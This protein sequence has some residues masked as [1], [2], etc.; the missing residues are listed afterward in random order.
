M[1]TNEWQEFFKTEAAVYN[2]ESFT[3]S[4]EAE[5]AFLLEEFQL[6]PGAAILDIGC[7]TGRHSLALAR[8]GFRMTGVDLSPEMLAIAGQAATAESLPV[9]LLCMDARDYHAENA[10][11]SAICL[12][13]GA[14]CLLGSQDD[15]LDR[16]LQILGNIQHALK[17]EG[18]F[19][20][21]VLNGSRLIRQSS[22]A[23]IT[24]GKYDYLNMVEHTEIE[25]DTPQGKQVIHVRERTY[26]PPELKRL[27]QQA[28]FEVLHLYG[29]TAGAWNRQTPQLDEME[30]MAIVRK[31]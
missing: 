2:Q 23:D 31:P 14:L 24:A 13:E 22:D 12:C 25:T 15:P 6:A 8:R 7:G 3:R 5:I 18:K 4:T 26:T 16:D 17:P 27:L 10:F 19:V 1:T 11:D 9:T 28:G 29:G 20:L 30:L 21:T